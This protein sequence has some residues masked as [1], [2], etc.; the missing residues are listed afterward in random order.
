[1]SAAAA[2]ALAAGAESVPRAQIS[3]EQLMHMIQSAKTR[4]DH[5]QIAAH[6][7]TANPGGG[8]YG[9]R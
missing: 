9:R 8:P 2:L 6:L 3:H 1:M 7:R 4:A 5:E